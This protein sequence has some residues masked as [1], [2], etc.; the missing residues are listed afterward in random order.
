M[1]DTS[2]GYVDLT[3]VVNQTTGQVR[4]MCQLCFGH[5]SVQ[6]LYELPD[7]SREDTCKECVVEEAHLI[8]KRRD[9]FECCHR[10]G[11]F[12]VCRDPDWHRT[13]LRRRNSPRRKTTTKAQPK[14]S[15]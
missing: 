2:R 4:V 15:S 3:R 5:F 9:E 12:V 7:G 14:E 10:T 1:F 11:N 13:E 6:D 8:N